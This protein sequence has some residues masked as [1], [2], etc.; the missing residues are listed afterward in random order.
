MAK[1][2]SGAPQS[3]SSEDPLAQSKQEDKLFLTV[4]DK[5]LDMAVFRTDVLGQ[6]TVKT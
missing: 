5:L 3:V 4:T 2:K 1:L 6:L